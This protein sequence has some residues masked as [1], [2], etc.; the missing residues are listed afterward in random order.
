VADRAHFA[1]VG[2]RS[3]GTLRKFT[4]DHHR[5]EMITKVPA[6][7]TAAL[8]QVN[9]HPALVSNV[10]DKSLD[11]GQQAAQAQVHIVSIGSLV[12]PPEVRRL[13]YSDAR[14][15]RIVITPL[16]DQPTNHADV[17]IPANGVRLG[18]EMTGDDGVQR[19]H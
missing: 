13:D 19:D 11:L 18:G 3:A 15:G 17:G 7:P 10:G 2:S 5:R 8:T 4:V 12:F 14:C 1:D 6:A 9:R 16:A